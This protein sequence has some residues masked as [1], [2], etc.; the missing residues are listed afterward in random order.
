MLLILYIT[1]VLISVL[2]APCLKKEDTKSVFPIKK[3]ECETLSSRAMIAQFPHLSGFNETA[4]KAALDMVGDAASLER[5]VLGTS[6]AEMLLH[7]LYEYLTSSFPCVMEAFC[8]SDS[9]DRRSELIDEV[10]SLDK[11][12]KYLL[13]L[14]SQLQNDYDAIFPH[15][16]QLGSGTTSNALEIGW[17][18]YLYLEH[19]PALMKWVFS[20]FDWDRQQTWWRTWEENEAKK[21]LAHMVSSTYIREFRRLKPIYA[22]MDELRLKLDRLLGELPQRKHSRWEVWYFWT[23]NWWSKKGVDNRAMEEERFRKWGPRW[24]LENI[25]QHLVQQDSGALARLPSCGWGI[26]LTCEKYAKPATKFE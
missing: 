19:E 23:P 8:N 15:Y 12:I 9:K 3:S 2:I 14:I 21:E 26:K 24:Y 22:S 7:E 25:V 1:A 5:L 18:K 4:H 11:K 20:A 6:Q 13:S 10:P 17:F 16:S